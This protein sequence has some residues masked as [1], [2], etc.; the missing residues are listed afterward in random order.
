MFMDVGNVENNLWDAVGHFI[1][2]IAKFNNGFTCKLNH[3]R[4]YKNVYKERN[5]EVC[6]V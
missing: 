1:F 4:F 2:Y 3:I 6:I 5:E